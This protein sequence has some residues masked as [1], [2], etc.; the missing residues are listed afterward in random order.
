L[1]FI[2]LLNADLFAKQPVPA[3]ERTAEYFHLLKNKR[4]GI[5]SNHTGIIG[6]KHI[7]DV[8]TE[9]KFN[10]TLI[11]APE[12]GFRGNAD[13]GE[14]VGD[15]T[16]S[17]TGIT[18]FSLYKN[19]SGKPDSASLAKI[20]LL[21]VDIQDVG[22]RF[23]TYYISLY[24]LM[25]ACA[26]VDIPVLLLDR[27]NPN[28]FY[29]DGPI[30]DMKHKSG[31][32]YLPIP[33][34]HGMTL[35]ELALMINGEKWLPR[36]KT[37]R[38]Q[39]IPCDEYT[40]ATKYTLPVAP[41]PNLPTMKSIWLYPSV[42]LFEGTKISLGR[43]TDFPFQVYGSPS[44]K[45]KFSFTP[46]SRAGAKNPPFK[47]Q[48]CFGKDLRKISDETIWN[49]GLNLQYIIDAYNNLGVGEKFFTDFF[50]KLIGVD[51][52]RRMIIEGHSA[53][54]I[55]AMW[56]EDVEKFKQQRE[57]YLLYEQ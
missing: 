23:Y 54:E 12:H 20:D 41:S 37:C 22:L 47:N 56:R 3:A 7:V 21:L 8:L 51:Y 45:G 53:A 25:D 28:G 43:G 13:A 34:V 40:H 31:V 33:V 50:E 18:I 30:L 4:I 9:N 19:K 35:G 49:N 14:K 57:K 46:R 32:G 26:D 52:V 17:R 55:K 15:T 48:K 36:G 42:C 44:M 6:N 5:F 10:V 38:L 29:V 27:P 24:K 2:I 1:F 16:D 39:V 11:F